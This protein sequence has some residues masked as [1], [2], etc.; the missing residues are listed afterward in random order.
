MQ[1]FK[2]TKATDLVSATKKLV[3]NTK[4]KFLA[5]GTNLLDLMKEDVEA[6]DELVDI[7]NLKPAGIK[8]LTLGA[9]RGGVSIGALGKNTDAAN[10]PLIKQNFPLLTQAILAGASVQ[11]RNM[12]T[13]G[14]N[15]NQRTRCPYFYEVAMP[16][17]KREPGTGCSA[18]G[19]VNKLH[20]IFGWTEACVAVHPSDMCVALAALDAVVKVQ[21]ASGERSILF[22]GYHR[23]PG[24]T[25]EKD[26]NLQRDELITAIEIPAN[27]FAAKSYYLK[28][29]DRSSYA[30][31]LISVAAA[32]ETVDT[33]IR[34][35]RI[36]L[37]GVAHKPWRALEAEKFLAGKVAT[38]A[39]FKEAA[40][41]ALKDA[42]PLKHNLYKVELTSKAIVRALLQAMN[43]GMHS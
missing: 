32:I 8:M 9:N 4:A 21:G 36:A 33:E 26:N 15:L 30:F 34:A 28:V 24:D 27:N 37:G 23:L 11:I 16:C 31:A 42:K 5:G 2:Y 35:A 25:P 43:G 29:R 10:H 40:A 7:T 17:N 19:G 20:A 12:A 41:I 39:V 38:E 6:P 3:A 22:N 1:P 13:N 14:G 18:V